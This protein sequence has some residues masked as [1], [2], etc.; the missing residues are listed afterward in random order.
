MLKLYDS[1]G[2]LIKLNDYIKLE[3]MPFV[4][5][6]HGEFSYYKVKLS[7]GIPIISYVCSDKGYILPPG[8]TGRILSDLYDPKSIIFGGCKKP[9]PDIDEIFVIDKSELPHKE[10]TL[11]A[12]D[13]M[14]ERKS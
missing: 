12:W 8:Y 10:I 11:K 7:H 9:Q 14:H 1:G 6:Q 4:D 5:D 3:V 13:K 2:T